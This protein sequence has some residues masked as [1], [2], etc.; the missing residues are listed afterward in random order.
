VQHQV[1]VRQIIIFGI[2]VAAAAA[3][4]TFF[5]MIQAL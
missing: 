3:A 5:V 1:T 2:V 4:Q